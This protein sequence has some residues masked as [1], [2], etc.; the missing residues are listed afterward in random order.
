MGP[1]GKDRSPYAVVL[2]M[3][4]TFGI[5]GFVWTYRVI[6]EVREHTQLVGIPA[7]G[8]AVALLFVPLVG[9]VWALVL[10]HQLPAWVRGVEEQ[11]GRPRLNA[12]LV[13][14]LF[15][16][17]VLWPVAVAMLQST[18]NE[19]WRFHRAEPRVVP[20]TSVTLGGA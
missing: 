19:H 12:A 3:G 1:L 18:L 6:R 17:I 14:V 15:L 8:R 4:A 11:H 9:V 10:A 13:F 7:P 20:L 5:Y 16:L 2:L